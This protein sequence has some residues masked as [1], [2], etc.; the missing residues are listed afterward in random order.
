LPARPFKSRYRSAAMRSRATPLGSVAPDG[1]P[2]EI[3][4]RLPPRGEAEFVHGAIPDGAA[5]LELGCGVGRITHELIRLGHPV[6]AVDESPEMLAHVRGAETVLS[7]IEDVD[8]RRRFPCVLLASHFVNTEEPERDL[9]LRACARHVDDD[10]ILVIERYDPMWTPE[11]S[12]ARR[13]GDV[14]VRLR[15][16]RREGTRSG[17]LRSTRWMGARGRS[18]SA[19]WCWTTASSALR[20]VAPASP[21]R[22]RS[23]STGSGSR[24]GYT[25]THSRCVISSVP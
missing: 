12:P 18:R 19:R 20:C 1:S 17:R 24:R 15:D 10:G 5:V 6:V 13:I 2:V 8:L 21:S 16:V 4:L 9:L 22:K 23:T 25:R 3:Y 7:R 14:S 11:A